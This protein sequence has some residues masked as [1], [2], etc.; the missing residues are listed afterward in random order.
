MQEGS[1]GDDEKEETNIFGNVISQKVKGRYDT[2]KK[3]EIDPVESQSLQSNSEG[4][5][6]R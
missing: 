4:N 3:I 2:K 6:S 5:S 1:I